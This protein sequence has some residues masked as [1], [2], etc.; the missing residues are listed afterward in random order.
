MPEP[1]WT[2]SAPQPS[3]GCLADRI[4]NDDRF[5]RDLARLEHEARGRDALRIY[6]EG[7]GEMKAK[8]ALKSYLGA[9]G[10]RRRLASAPDAVL[11]PASGEPDVVTADAGM[12][13]G[14]A[15]ESAP[16]KGVS[17][18]GGS[19]LRQT[20]Q[21]TEQAGAP[22]CAAEHEQQGPH[23]PGTAGCA[24]PEPVVGPSAQQVSVAPAS[25]PRPAGRE[26]LRMARDGTPTMWNG[27]SFRVVEQTDAEIVMS[28]LTGQT[29]SRLPSHLQPR[30]PFGHR[31]ALRQCP[32][33]PELHPLPSVDRRSNPSPAAQPAWSG[34][35]R[36]PPTSRKPSRLHRSLNRKA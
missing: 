10:E 24:A 19:A 8:E 18:N 4:A 11:P 13:Q 5:L 27:W 32:R 15:P 25:L 6:V 34:L 20:D 26:V 14:A 16:R 17:L 12:H 23:I 9:Q 29:A 35:L 36:A 1:S 22:T 31:T 2:G 7:A 28:R 3:S 30:R 21:S 33:R